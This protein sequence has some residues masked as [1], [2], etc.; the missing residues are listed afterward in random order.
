MLP[1][2]TIRDGC[3]TITLNRPDRHNV[4]EA[5]DLPALG[6][7]LDTAEANTDL[8]TLVLTA[9]GDKTFS[10]GFN[11]S[12]IESTNWTH[13]PLEVVVD[14][15]EQFA[16]PTVCALNG[17]V[18]GGG[19][20]LAL[21]CDFRIG[22]HG[23]RLRVPA[24]KLGVFYYINGLKRFVE[25]LGP[26]ATRRIFLLGE[27]LADTELLACGYLDRL[28]PREELEQTTAGIIDCLRHAA[29]LAIRGMKRAIL[30]LSRG[31]L[32]EDAARRDVVTCFASEDAMEGARAFAEKRVPEFK[33]L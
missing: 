10:A 20:D 12:D 11:I 14:R 6:E 7:L 22:V 29:P 27:E 24:V 5:A 4:I 26:G 18:F 32:N 33:G 2:M 25:R 16:L 31:C 15:L 17:N 30:D 1:D 21:A 23:M 28:V 19:T 13:N 8:R 3:A 9:T